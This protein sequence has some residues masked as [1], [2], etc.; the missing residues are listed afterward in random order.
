M[1]NDSRE[2]FEWV[3]L[4]QDF[5]GEVFSVT[6]SA[7]ILAN[8]GQECFNTRQTCPVPAE[9]TLAMRT[10]KFCKPM[11]FKP[12][13]WDWLPFL[14]SCNISGASI[15]PVGANQNNRV[16]GTRTSLSF[17]L[18]D[19]PYSDRVT[20]P[21]VDNRIGRIPTY[22]PEE[23][24]TFWTKWKARNPFYLGR[25]IRYKSAYINR[26]TGAL[27]DI[28]TMHYFMS[29]F[30]GPDQSGR[31]SI[32]AR[33]L[34]S[35]FQ[36][37]NVQ[38]PPANTGK[39]LTDTAPATTSFTL[40]PA[41]IGDEQY[42]SSGFLCIGSDVFAFTRTGDVVAVGARYNGL[43]AS[44]HKAGDVVQQCLYIEAK[45]PA[46]IMNIVCSDVAGMPPEYLD[47]A[48]WVAE[49]TSYMPR[50]YTRMIA[51]PEGLEA[52]LSSMSTNMYFYP[53]W[54]ERNALLKIRAVRPAEGDVIHDVSEFGGVESGTGSL[55][56]EVDQLFTQ[57]HVYF[58]QLDPTKGQNDKANYAA[59]EILVTDGGAPSKHGVQVIKEIFGSWI[60]RG[61]AATAVDLGEK[62]TARYGTIPKAFDFTVPARG[63]GH[64]WVGDFIRVETFLNVD[65]FGRPV[66]MN[67]QIMS[68]AISRAKDM[69]KFRAQEFVFEAPVDPTEKL[70]II[71]VDTENLNLRDA[72]DSQFGVPPVAGDKI[73]FEIR[74][75]VVIGGRGY[76]GEETFT[77][78]VTSV[79][80]D[81]PAR[82]YSRPLA[83]LMRHGLGA[84]VTKA[85]GSVYSAPSG[86]FVLMSD[87]KEV[88]C[89]VAFDTGLWPVGV[90]LSLVQSPG[91]Y[92][93]GESGFSSCCGGVSSVTAASPVTALALASD[94]GNALRIRHPITWNNQGVI[95]AGGAGGFPAIAN[96]W[97]NSNFWGKGWLF[98]MNPG[99]SGA[100]RFSRPP[101]PSVNPF[102]VADPYYV[103]NTESSAGSLTAGGYGTVFTLWYQ[104]WYLRATGSPGGALANGAAPPTQS[105][106]H[107]NGT[108][109]TKS[110]I[111]TH[112]GS[113]GYAIIEGASLITWVNKGDVRGPEVA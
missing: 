4:D 43:A 51:K 72:Y 42:D 20:D 24:G 81:Q 48:Q 34:L 107:A 32:S 10:L 1:N 8:A 86:N 91:S 38:I 113:G 18:Q 15:N 65:S 97:Q 61:G 87:V 29:D 25:P 68:A 28:E 85:R 71:V 94:G 63:F 83:P 69:Y 44:S 54:D 93:V 99:G 16:L 102:T 74:P 106:V 41:G 98:G 84:P 64:L 89:S 46:E 36:D 79:F 96:F 7:T 19:A 50:L 78:N 104:N 33:D 31:V 47:T 103:V 100:G 66:P 67:M 70:V 60:P 110:P 14:E 77:G 101:L 105:I 35:R 109:I 45:S 40:D 3:E 76:V 90:N 92:I 57:C 62:F 26:E 56:D 6:C 39:L 95:S 82:V 49:Q 108:Y 27:E 75:G 9:Y 80:D 37:R 52:C 59:R 73:R 5:C 30:D 13:G 23:L 58:G 111:V 21:Y 112:G 55:T 12:D 22:N 17:T 88:P 2:V 53:I 11:A